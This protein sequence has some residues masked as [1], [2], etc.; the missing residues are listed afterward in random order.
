MR[1]AGWI[2][3]GVIAGISTSA[4]IGTTIGIIYGLD[5]AKFSHKTIRTVANM[6]KSRSWYEADASATYGNPTTLEQK[7][8][9]SGLLRT[10]LLGN[11]EY[12]HNNKT[13]KWDKSNHSLSVTRFD[14]ID[15]ILLKDENED[16]IGWDAK[17][18]KPI[19][20]SLDEYERLSSIDKKKFQYNDEVVKYDT[21]KGTVEAGDMSIVNLEYPKAGAAFLK[22]AELAKGGFEAHIRDNVYWVDNKGQKTTYKLK[23]EDFEYSIIRTVLGGSRVR[24]MP[25]SPTNPF[26]G[27]GS[28]RGYPDKKN[29]TSVNKDIANFQ[30]ILSREAN[31]TFTNLSNTNNMPNDYL[32]GLYNYQGLNKTGVPKTTASGQNSPFSISLDN[33]KITNIFD[34]PFLNKNKN[35]NLNLLSFY[36]APTTPADKAAVSPKDTK[37]N[38]KGILTVLLGNSMVLSP[39]PSEYIKNE[40]TNRKLTTSTGKQYEV[41]E[42]LARTTGFGVYASTLDLTLSVAPMYMSESTTNRTKFK[43]NPYFYNQKWVKSKNSMD[44]WIRD[45]ILQPDKTLFGQS[46]LAAFRN[47]RISGM[48]LVGQPKNKLLQLQGSKKAIFSKGFESINAIGKLFPNLSPYATNKKSFNFNDEYSKLVYGATRDDLVAGKAKTIK[49]FVSPKSIEFRSL[50]S[51]AINWFAFSKELNSDNTKVSWLLKT[52]PNMAINP[53]GNNNKET[54]ESR[55][56]EINT[57]KAFASNNKGLVEITDKNKKPVGDWKQSKQWFVDKSSNKDVAMQSPQFAK[58]QQQMKTLLDNNVANGKQ[59]VFQIRNYFA[60]YASTKQGLDAAIKLINSIYPE[61][62]RVGD[63]DDPNNR[64]VTYKRYQDAAE[65]NSLFGKSSRVIAGGWGADYQGFGTM[66]TF[67][68]TYGSVPLSAAIKEKSNT[69][70]SYKNLFPGVIAYATIFEEEYNKFKAKQDPEIQKGL[71][72]FSE[73]SGLTN[74]RKHS[75]RFVSALVKE[76]WKDLVPQN[77]HILFEQFTNSKLSSFGSILDRQIQVLSLERSDPNKNPTASQSLRDAYKWFTTNDNIIK[78]LRELKDITGTEVEETSNILDPSTPTARLVQS[79]L[80]LPIDG[81]KLYSPLDV[82]VDATVQQRKSGPFWF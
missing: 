34:T 28:K 72:D 45:Y 57:T 6:V 79:Y 75:L 48:A 2:R 31:S 27:F 42:G 25:A 53:D 66:L 39:A 73:L 70:S 16:L 78:F 24:L 61:K 44:E 82:L 21:E 4:I 67:F 37:G 76:N 46:Q 26:G 64:G 49:S 43:K 55:I 40:I 51:S 33:K 41:P 59:V 29:P 19:T 15:Y 18:G 50:I 63:L 20:K 69:L 23:P 77:K 80:Q 3:T 17:N 81:T 60:S 56:D 35:K 62:L 71:Y 11:D 36:T 47:Q 52:P 13:G 12:V 74:K 14:L 58:I 5:D 10:S 30:S 9:A 38:L 65:R 32:Y 54:F 1:K 7:M 68:D 22:V 8:S